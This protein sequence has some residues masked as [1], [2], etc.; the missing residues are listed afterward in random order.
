MSDANILEI[1]LSSTIL[2]ATIS[3]L[4]SFFSNRRKDRIENITKERKTWRDELR[5]LCAE[6]SGYQNPDNLKHVINKLKVYINPHGVEGKDYSKDCHIWEQI[7]A[8]EDLMS[9]AKNSATDKT[10][11]DNK[12]EYYKNI[13]ICFVSCLLKYDWERSKREVDDKF[14]PLFVGIS[15]AVSFMLYTLRYYYDGINEENITNYISACVFFYSI[16]FWT[17][18]VY[19]FFKY[20]YRCLFSYIYTGIVIAW[21]LWSVFICPIAN[22]DCIN[23]I[24]FGIP[25]LMLIF[26]ECIR[27]HDHYSDENKHSATANFFLEK[28]KTQ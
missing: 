6:I 3:S 7:H 8:F 22:F 19:I 26:T 16:S 20:E 11:L 18:L 21:F 4:F 15:L 5:G 25:S 1:V 10:E 23:I 12:L 17:V 9:K 28:Y 13:F 27:I 24:I 2:S 14:Q